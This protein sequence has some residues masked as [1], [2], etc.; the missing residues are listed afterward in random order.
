M[1]THWSDRYVGRV[2]EA[3]A[4]DCGDLAELVAREVFGRAIALPSV[5]GRGG[6]Q[7]QAVIDAAKSACAEPI[8]KPCDGDA[9]L[10]VAR[11]YGQHVGIYCVIEGE[12]WVLH[13]VR[14]AGAIRTRLR[15][16]GLLGYSIE[17]YYRWA[18]K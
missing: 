13:N 4:F 15:H 2:Y 6:A 12:P 5:H 9:V 17:G 16:M 7:R 8:A 1:N 18:S 3:G 14:T 11:G 10:I